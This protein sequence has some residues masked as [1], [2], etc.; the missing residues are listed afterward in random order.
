MAQSRRNFLTLGL[1]LGGGY[2]ALKYGA[3]AVSSLF[4]DDFEFEPISEPVGFRRITSGE[5]T[6]GFDPFFGIGGGPDEDEEM[7]AVVSEV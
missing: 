2:A 7:L 4:A 6:S 5:S 3:P 1:V